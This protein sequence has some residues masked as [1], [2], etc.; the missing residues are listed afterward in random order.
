MLSCENGSQL[1][2]YRLFF[3]V[4]CVEPDYNPLTYLRGSIRKKPLHG[5]N[6]EN[7]LPHIQACM[8]RLERSKKRT[9]L[10]YF[11]LGTLIHYIADCFTFAHNPTFPGNLR[12]HRAYELSLHAE[13]PS[14]LS[15]YLSE[16]VRVRPDSPW[17]LFSR[18]HNSYA[19]SAGNMETDCY[20]IV[21]TC[22]DILESLLASG[23]QTRPAA[24]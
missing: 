5:H 1:C 24:V 3:L 22:Q 17:K 15:Q 10:W 16:M 21:K 2:S 7:V 4:G 6:V 14:R 19:R 18:R 12:T 13:F 20:Y 9:A 8:N 11:S 23:P